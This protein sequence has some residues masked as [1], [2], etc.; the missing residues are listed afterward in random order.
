MVSKV[1]NQI[2]S[3]SKVSIAVL[4]ALAALAPLAASAD[5]AD[6]WYH[7]GIVTYKYGDDPE[8]KYV[9]NST[10]MNTYLMYWEMPIWITK[11]CDQSTCGLYTPQT[12]TLHHAYGNTTYWV[13]SP[14][15]GHAMDPTYQP[16][17]Q[18][19]GGCNQ[20]DVGKYRCIV[21]TGGLGYYWTLEIFYE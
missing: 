9:I 18:L 16:Q 15:S 2:P 20:H 1:R 12:W 17:P 6:H 5:T 11:S 3:L 8:V 7:H 14:T 4:F 19:P 13:P 21:G 10:D